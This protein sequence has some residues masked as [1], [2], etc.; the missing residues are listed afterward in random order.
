VFGLSFWELGLVMLVALLVLGPK[1]LPEVARSIGKGLQELRKA[2]VD[3]RS[4]IEE[5]LEEVRKPLRDIRD[6]LMDTVYRAEE[7]IQRGAHD[8]DDPGALHRVDPNALAGDDLPVEGPNTA[9][10]PG[11]TPRDDSED[12]D[13]EAERRQREV[14]AIYAQAAKEGAE[15]V[16]GSVPEARGAR[17]QEPGPP[18]SGSEDEDPGPRQS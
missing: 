8:A 10:P 15:G 7:E 5:P 12:H 2:S 11:A 17:R 6:D 13:P 14:E 9:F 16:P 3:L 18:V 4:A 1:R